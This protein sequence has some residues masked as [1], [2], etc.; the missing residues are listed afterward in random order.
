MSSPSDNNPKRW[1]EEELRNV[2]VPE[3]LRA[4][5]KG[6]AAATDEELDIALRDVTLPVGLT[7]QLKSIPADESL[8]RRL[9]EVPI[10]ASLTK[11]LHDIAAMTDGELDIQLTDIKVPVNLAADLRSIAQTD[12]RIRRVRWQMVQWAVA[13]SLL[14]SVSVAYMAAAGNMIMAMFPGQPS[15]SEPTLMV[16]ANDAIEMEWFF[17]DS[18]SWDNP[19][20]EQPAPVRP[21]QF[22]DEPAPV[23]AQWDVNFD[24]LVEPAAEPGMLAEIDSLFTPGGAGY[25][26]PLTDIFLAKHDFL[27]TPVVDT[28][29]VLETIDTM[30]L[31]GVT[32]PLV[33]AAKFQSLIVD[34]KAPLVS[35]SAD[36]LLST[37]RVPLSC[38]TLGYDL[39]WRELLAGRIPDGNLLR[40]EDFLAGLNYDFEL[41]R[42]AA[43]G[44]RTAAGPA[45]FAEDGLSLLQIGV[46]ATAVVQKQ[47]PVQLTLA[48]DASVSM[49]KAGQFAQLRRVLSRLD[50][51]LGSEDR[52]SV[53][54]LSETTEVLLE[55]AAPEDW[56][57]LDFLLDSVPTRNSSNLA[58]GL[59]EAAL[60]ARRSADGQ[61]Q[62]RLVLITDGL[63]EA[64]PAVL[65]QLSSMAEDL[66]VA[67]MPV[68]VVQLLAL[69]GSIDSGLRTLATAGEGR[70]YTAESA[71]AIRSSLVEVASGP[72][73]VVA[74]AAKLKVEFLP[75]VV[76]E[77]RLVGHEP[78]GSGGLLGGPLEM[79]LYAGQTATAL[80][81][82]KL[83]PTGGD[84]VA[85]AELTWIDAKT[86]KERTLRQKI[87]RLQFA[88]S[89]LE[90]PVSLQRAAVA[91]QAVEV[92][93][94]SR[95]S[96]ARASGLRRL[97][98][99]ATG[100]PT[101]TRRDPAFQQMLGL[102]DTALR[103]QT[104]RSGN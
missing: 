27:A 37:A 3:G 75:E 99:H 25:V 53:V 92:L 102:I 45:P 28:V 86:G 44:L 20:L 73:Q 9:K 26:N 82:V 46:P 51:I 34:G 35:P 30:P 17:E 6:I 90:S 77:Y 87:S 72:D 62:Q 11:R 81:E 48:I 23:V 52:L 54:L 68:D 50:D 80:F 1:M 60:V 88:T 14:I 63:R 104:G 4:R 96:S 98:Q 97:S 42:K 76:A 78:N 71:E 84:D 12:I 94:L 5:L 8:D 66:A 83:K 65:E 7:N 19:G 79:N 36:R 33:P 100:L 59:R 15:E 69:Q 39:A 43:L 41:P 85:V 95:S 47:P 10:P 89:V 13:A 21:R 91:A 64:T 101:H 2:P 55:N 22:L 70:L 16:A 93:R 56:S 38:S 40:T 67:K 57:Q 74:R 61:H 24:P 31:R 103:V 29:P 49:T 32:P 18:L 58:G